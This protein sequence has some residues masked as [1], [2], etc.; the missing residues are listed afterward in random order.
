LC[1]FFSKVE[2]LI[3]AGA[4]VNNYISSGKTA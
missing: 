4:N 2:L 3:K 1:F